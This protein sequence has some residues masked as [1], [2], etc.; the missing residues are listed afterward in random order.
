YEFLVSWSHEARLLY[1]SLASIECVRTAGGGWVAPSNRVF[2]PRQ[3]DEVVFPEGLPVPIANVPN[4]S[5][6][7]SLLEEAGVRAFEWR[8][9]IPEFVLPLLTNPEENQDMRRSALAA[10]RGYFRTERTGDARMLNQ[11]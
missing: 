4:V 5:G 3:R 1:V 8:L 10:L 11:I 7:R 9:L 2:F 6:L